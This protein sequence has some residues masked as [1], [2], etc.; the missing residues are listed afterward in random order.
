MDVVR[1][2]CEWIVMDNVHSALKTNLIYLVLVRL[3]FQNIHWILSNHLDNWWKL[4]SILVCVKV[5]KSCRGNSCKLFKLL[6]ITFYELNLTYN[7]Y[8][9]SQSFIWKG[10]HKHTVRED[11]GWFVLSLI[12]KNAYKWTQISLFQ[13]TGTFSLKKCKTSVHMGKV[14]L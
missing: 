13:C 1:L 9:N 2:A 4:Y 11:V 6:P 12:A 7:L 10:K 14:L 5:I 8:R 3:S